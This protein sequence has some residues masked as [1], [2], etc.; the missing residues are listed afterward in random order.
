MEFDGDPT[1]RDR[2]SQH[3]QSLYQAQ[4]SMVYSALLRP[5]S[6]SATPESLELFELTR[7]VTSRKSLV[8]SIVSLF[9][10]SLLLDSD[11]TRTALEGHGGLLDETVLARFRDG[12]LPVSSVGEL[13]TLRLEEFRADWGR[14]PEDLRR[15]GSVSNSV[16]HGLTRINT[17]NREFFSLQE[18]KP[19][20]RGPRL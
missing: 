18:E 9:Y 15:S 5:A 13:G 7:T 3:L 14:L 10:P 6:N 2:V 19:P 17:L 8:R 16:A 20:P 11:G 12:N 4:Q 1:I